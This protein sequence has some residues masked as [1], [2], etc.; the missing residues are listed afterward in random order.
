MQDLFEFQIAGQKHY[1]ERHLEDAKTSL[2]DRQTIM[3][4]L[5]DRDTQ[6]AKMIA[7]LEKEL[8]FAK[9]QRAQLTETK[10]QGIGPALA[11]LEK[12]I[13][14]LE[15]RIELLALEGSTLTT[16]KDS[17]EKARLDVLSRQKESLDSLLTLKVQQSYWDSYYSMR[18]S[19]IDEHCPP[20]PMKKVMMEK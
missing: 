7:N 14:S 5:A 18:R 12:S 6:R 13:E 17:L 3:A 8:A 15:A 16:R 10:G 19:Q 2:A 9:D 20:P 1:Y 11:E 4:N